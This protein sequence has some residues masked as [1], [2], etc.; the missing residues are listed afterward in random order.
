MKKVIFF[1]FPYFIGVCVNAQNFEW[2]KTVGGTGLDMAFD[3][4]IDPWGNIYATG[5][6]RNTADFDPG[7]GIYNLTSNGSDDIFIL[8]LDAFGNFLWAKSIG[9][10]TDDFGYSIA[11]DEFGDVYT[12]GHF[13]LTADFDGGS[14]IFNMTASVRDA[15]IQKM[16]P[17]GNFLWA[18]KIDGPGHDRS[19]SICADKNGHIYTTGFFTTTADF[20]PG[21]S[22]FPLTATG[23][24]DGYILKLDLNGDFAWAGLIYGTSNGPSGES[25][26][27]DSLGNIFVTG[28]FSDTIDLDPGTG[29]YTI[30]PL[31]NTNMFILKL[32]ATGNFSFG[33]QVGGIY[34]DIDANKI[35]LDNNSNI[36]LTG[37]YVDSID[38][39]PGLDS[40]F[41]ASNSITLYD[42]FLMKLDPNGNFL[43]VKSAGG[44]GVDEAKSVIIDHNQFIYVSTIFQNTVDFDPG[45]GT[46]NLSSG[47]GS[48]VCIWKLDSSGNLVNTQQITGSGSQ[49]VVSIDMDTSGN[50]YTTGT[51]GGPTDFDPS[52]SVYNAAPFGSTDVFIHKLSQDSCAN[53]TLVVDSISN[54]SCVTS[55]CYA[56]SFAHSGIAPYS[57]VWNTVPPT[58]DSVCSFN[59]SGIYE[60]VLTDFNGCSRNKSILFSGPS[61]PGD[62][63][64]NANMIC[65]AFRPDTNTNI[66]LN[67]FNDGC[68]TVSGQLIFILDN[69][70]TLNYSFPSPTSINGDSLIWNFSALNYNSAHIMPHL[71]VYNSASLA[72]GDSVHFKLIMT[73][74]FGDVYTI[75]NIKNYAFPVTNGYD[76]NDKKIYPNGIC[77]PQFIL[78]GEILTYTIRFQNTGNDE[79]YNIYVIDSIDSNLDI[80]SVRV[81]GSSH[82]MTTEILPGQVLKFKFDNIMLIDSNSNEPASHGYVIFEVIPNVGTLNNTQIQNTAHIYFDYNPPISTNTRNNTLINSIPTSSSSISQIGCNSLL[83]NGYLYDSTGIYFQ[84]LDNFIGCDSMITLDLTIFDSTSNIITTSACDSYTLNSIMYNSSGVYSQTLTNSVGC[85]SILVLDLTINNVDNTLSQSGFILTANQLSATYQWIDCNNSNLPITGE[86][87]QAFTA[88]SNGNYAVIVTANGCTDTSV[89]QAIF[90]FGIEDQNFSSGLNAS[91][92]PTNS[93]INIRST[94]ELKNALLIITDPNGKNLFQKNQLNGNSFQFD[95]SE[96][97]SGMYFL[98]L[99]SEGKEGVIKVVKN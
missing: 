58:L 81:V 12:T 16:D 10:T 14:G 21:P 87:N 68:D 89:C 74:I 34:G 38:F 71:N 77:N 1:I 48:D 88:T 42:L 7:S 75:N 69:Q 94:I 20:D 76:P 73:P 93:L 78:N 99:Y 66:W 61:Y 65:N 8:K 5:T 52:I 36:Y 29:S 41:L 53:L 80:N 82:S 9:S 96:L 37:S 15:F 86:T 95:L 79:A 59:A 45:P 92:N 91:P 50:I 64:L 46:Y 2:A 30:I 11:I 54:Y 51:I 22:F 4:K 39:D 70:C 40:F 27:A 55:S 18:K 85:D 25:V 83:I 31:G 72:I 19:Y 44:I 35:T 84:H 43:W 33:G 28:N 90:G 26:F 57:Y 24:T 98:H 17:M 6:F 60:I 62:F 13:G 3:I 97:N 63:D 67:A 56:S 23:I 49:D 32:D 47:G